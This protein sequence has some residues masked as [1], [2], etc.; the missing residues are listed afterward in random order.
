MLMSMY[1]AL[2]RL[3]GWLIETL[4]LS[5]SDVCACHNLEDSV[6]PGQDL[7]EPEPSPS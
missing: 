1:R 7:A 5:T 6:D 2:V 3:A 4:G